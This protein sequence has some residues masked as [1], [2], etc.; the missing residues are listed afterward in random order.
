MTNN[1]IAIT[2]DYSK[3]IALINS[4]KINAFIIKNKLSRRAYATYK[5]NNICNEKRLSVLDCLEQLVISD[6]KYFEQS[7]PNFK[8]D[9]WNLNR[10][11]KIK[12][13]DSEVQ[14]IAEY[15][16]RCFKR[17]CYPDVIKKYFGKD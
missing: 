6:F 2:Y 12:E 4:M 1:E 3:H 8:K 7:F 13:L 15:L 5:Y 17:I 14:E 9:D 10:K 16:Y 11:N